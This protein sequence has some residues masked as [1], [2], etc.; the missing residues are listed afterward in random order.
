M[1][2]K[3]VE[4][5]RS[6]SAVALSCGQHVL[7]HVGRIGRR[8]PIGSVLCHFL[9]PLGKGLQRKL[10]AVCAGHSV[11]EQGVLTR[12]I[13]LGLLQ[14]LHEVGRVGGAFWVGSVEATGDDSLD[15]IEAYC[16][17]R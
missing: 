6:V 14:L 17:G 11:V 9:L 12:M 4:A 13:G 8:V 16:A 1:R 7:P 5:A 3:K 15:N 2:S 10:L